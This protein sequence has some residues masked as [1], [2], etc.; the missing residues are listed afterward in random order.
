M[1]DC[2]SLP[3]RWWAEGDSDQQAEK[4][5]WHQVIVGAFGWAVLWQCRECGQYWEG[6]VTCSTRSPDC[7][8]KFRGTQ[9]DWSSRT[10]VDYKKYISEHRLENKAEQLKKELEREGY[11]EVGYFALYS[12]WDDLVEWQ[13]IVGGKKRGWFKDG[14]E[15][16]IVL[17]LARNGEVCSI[18]DSQLWV[19][20]KIGH[21]KIRRLW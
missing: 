9:R 19:Q 4:R 20:I 17:I 11:N 14:P 7:V 6:Y 3:D 13:A 16:K 18:N 21:T 10:Q 15:K 2:S 8:A 5:G 12:P 1:C